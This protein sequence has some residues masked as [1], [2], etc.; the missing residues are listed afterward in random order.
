MNHSIHA[1]YAVQAQFYQQTINPQ[2]STRYNKKSVVN[3]YAMNERMKSCSYAYT[4][5]L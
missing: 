2:I 5:L 1:Q 4:C 3:E